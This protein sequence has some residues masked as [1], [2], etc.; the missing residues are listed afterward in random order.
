[1]VWVS[2]DVAVDLRGMFRV[3]QHAAR[4]S[5]PVQIV[6]KLAKRKSVKF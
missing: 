4:L 3:F 2:Y 6:A 1:M 5:T